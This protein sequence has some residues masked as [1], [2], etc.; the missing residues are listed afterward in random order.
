MLFD[1]RGG[2]RRNMVKVVYAVLAI[3]MGASLFLTVG[4]FSIGELFNNEGGSG[5]AAKPYQE[6]AE[7]I[8]AK[9]EKNPEDPDLLVSLTRAQINAG[10]AQAEIN[11]ATGQRS[12]TPEG[13]QEY[14]KAYQSWSEY[15]KATDEPSA[16]LALVVAPTLFQLAEFSRTYPE[17][18]SRVKSAT[19]AQE[20][21]AE[22]RP[23]VG[24]FT[25]LASYA[26]FTGDYA[27]AEKARAEAKKLANS[28]TER[29]AIDKQLDAYKKSADR[30]L[31]AKKKA[32][33][34]EKAAREGGGAGGAAGQPSESIENPLFGGGGLGE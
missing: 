28:S 30:Y 21:V 1:L 3:L 20:I 4:P 15:L 8:E 31:K 25:T 19:E 5:D 11:E 17:A 26:Y 9:L 13:I 34:A 2:H 27:A 14:Q 32:E 18:S 10:N 33:A 7:R 24:S 29:G 22:Q 23:N 16:G 12:F 6:Q